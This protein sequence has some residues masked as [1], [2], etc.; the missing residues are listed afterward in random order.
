[1]QEKRNAKI[2]VVSEDQDV[3]DFFALEAMALDC[4][5]MVQ[6]KPP[7]ETTSFDLIV[8]DSRAGYCFSERETCRVISVLFGEQAQLPKKAEEERVLWYWPVSVQEVRE[9]YLSVLHHDRAEGNDKRNFGEPVETIFFFT[10]DSYR[11]LYRNQVIHLTENEWRIL[12]HLGE[13]EGNPLSRE[14]FS[15]IVD[16]KGGN[17]LDVH[18]CHLRK[19]LEDPFGKKLIFTVRNRGYLIKASLKEM[20]ELP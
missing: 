4:S 1:M 10:D 18:I 17:A 19:K 11:I 3:A 8:L 5:V 2:C 6:R 14:T 20:A 16:M 9:A 12:R 15:S 7:E 13:G